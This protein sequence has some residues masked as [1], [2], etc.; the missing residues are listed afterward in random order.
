MQFLLQFYTGQQDWID[1][2]TVPHGIVQD[3]LVLGF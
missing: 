3:I 2:L 1:V